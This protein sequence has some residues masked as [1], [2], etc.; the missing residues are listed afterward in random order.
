MSN[1]P[2]TTTNQMREMVLKAKADFIQ[3][4]TDDR[5][6]QREALFATQALMNNDYLYKT[7]KENEASLKVAITN[8]ALTGTTLNPVLQKA[9]LVPRSVM[10]KPMVCLDF[11]YRGLAGIAMDSGAVKHIQPY[12]VYTFD[13]FT[14]EIVNGEPKINHKPELDP[15]ADFTTETFWKF[16]RCGY[17]ISILGDGTRII[18]PPMGKLQLEKAM[19]TSKTTGD[20]TPWRTHPDEQCK[21]TIVK[22]TYKL[23]PQTPQMSHAVAALNEHEGIDTTTEGTAFVTKIKGIT[24]D[25]QEP[26]PD[27][28]CVCDDMIEQKVPKWTCDLCG[29]KELPK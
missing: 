11:G 20:K 3:T 27:P 12:L 15:P 2:L 5:V 26:K 10:G 18:S 23:L 19:K 21:K 28:V 9:Y 4:V 22:H 16:L 24:Q 8:V 7:A 25:P 29:L 17:C 13:D 14:Y 1:N 6:W